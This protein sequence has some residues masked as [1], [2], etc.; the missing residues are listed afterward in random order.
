MVGAGTASLDAG[1]KHDLDLS[2]L[3]AALADVLRLVD[4]LQRTSGGAVELTARAGLGAG[5][6][7]LEGDDAAVAS[8]IE[9]LRSRR[10]VTNVMVLR[11]SGTLKRTVD[12]W[13]TPPDSLRLMQALKRSFDPSGMLNADRGPI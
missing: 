6:L 12:P 9:R 11:Q 7:R 5:F 3:P 10:I 13:G 8:A 1:R 4:E 2:W